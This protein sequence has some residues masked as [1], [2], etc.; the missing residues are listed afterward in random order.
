MREVTIGGISQFPTNARDRRKSEG[1]LKAT[2]E[3]MVSHIIYTFYKEINN[4][5]KANNAYTYHLT[6]RYLN[7]VSLNF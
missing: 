7:Q 4:M 6:Y 1:H 5:K 3:K 2:G